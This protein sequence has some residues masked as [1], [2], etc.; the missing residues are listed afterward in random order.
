MTISYLPNI[1]SKEEAD[2][3]FTITLETTEVCAMRNCMH[4]LRCMS[5]QLPSIPTACAA[6]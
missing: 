3:H 2:L 6:P 4:P 1:A 5:R